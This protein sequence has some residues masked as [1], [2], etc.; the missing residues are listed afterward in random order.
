MNALVL[1]AVVLGLVACKNDP[2]GGKKPSDGAPPKKTEKPEPLPGADALV[3]QDVMLFLEGKKGEFSIH[4]AVKGNGKPVL[5]FNGL[6][7]GAVYDAVNQKLIWTPDYASAN[8]PRDP[9]ILNKNYLVDVSLVSSDDLATVRLSRKVILNV[10]D[11]AKPAAVK[12]PL[13]M[14]GDEGV[15]LTHIIKFEDQEY[16][17]GPFEIA[18]SG[19][20][21]G[22]ELLWPDRKVPSFTLRWLPG[23]TEVKNVNSANFTGDITLYNLR[24]KSLQFSVNWKINDRKQLPRTSGPTS[25]IQGAGDLDFMVM[26]ED[27]NGEEVPEWKVRSGPPYGIFS[28]SPQASPGPG[29]PRII[30]L[31]TWKAIPKDKLGTIQEVTLEACVDFSY[32]TQYKVKLLPVATPPSQGAR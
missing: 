25:V 12:S 8:D 18:L 13:D 30:G 21:L 17:N 22:A 31:V 10:T 5:Q 26:A 29:L 11:V 16:P 7:N 14:T 2:Y 32:C 20:P 1:V 15:Q 4:N 28:V 19:L 24:G 23:F 3:I 27:L 6:P 9:A